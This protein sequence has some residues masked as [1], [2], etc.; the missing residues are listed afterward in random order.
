MSFN[1][2]DNIG[3]F[4]EAT[5]DTIPKDV[6]ESPPPETDIKPYVVIFFFSLYPHS[7]FCLLFHYYYQVVQFTHVFLVWGWWENH[8]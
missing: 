7:V 6:D 1:F 5:P 4:V 8:V 3:S 2:F